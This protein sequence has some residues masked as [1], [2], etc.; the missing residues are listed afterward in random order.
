LLT[1]LWFAPA[2]FTHGLCGLSGIAHGVT[3]YVGLRLMG[4]AHDRSDPLRFVAPGSFGHADCRLSRGWPARCR[5]HLVAMSTAA[6]SSP[7]D[8]NA[9]RTA[10]RKVVVAALYTFTP[11]SGHGTIRAHG[12]INRMPAARQ[13]GSERSGS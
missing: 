2:I 9:A 8:C 7:P 5:C 1:A 13:A 10:R 4:S 3:A 11:G 6:K 12:L